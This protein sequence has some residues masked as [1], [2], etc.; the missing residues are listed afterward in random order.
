MRASLNLQGTDLSG[1]IVDPEH[2]GF[3]REAGEKSA[4]DRQDADGAGGL[5]IEIDRETTGQRRF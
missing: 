4:S 1:E 2:A 5:L 3:L